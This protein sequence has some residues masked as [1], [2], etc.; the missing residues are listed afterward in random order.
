MSATL[1][2]PVPKAFGMGCFCWALGMD[3]T[4]VKSYVL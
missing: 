1:K 4:E 2:R 3:E